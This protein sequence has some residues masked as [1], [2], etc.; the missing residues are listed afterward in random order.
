MLSVCITTYN[1]ASGL[2]RTLESLSKQTRMPDELII[3]DN[4]SPDN[5]ADIAEKWSAHFKNFKYLRN[6][7]NVGMPG[8]LNNAISACSG[9]FILNL[10]DADTYQPELIEK[11]EKLIRQHPEVGIVFWATSSNYKENRGIDRITNGRDFFLKHFFR[12]TSSKIW[13]TVLARKEVYDQLMPFDPQFK[14]WADVDMWMR[15]CL[16]WDI[17]YISDPLMELFKEEGQFRYW[18]WQKPLFIYQMFFLNIVRH[19]DDLE[20][21]E[22]A[23]KRQLL[24][25][26]KRWICFMGGKL[27]RGNLASF[28]RGLRYMPAY[29]SMPDIADQ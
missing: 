21:R 19:F 27:R 24:Q 25:Q 5:T 1:R 4:A 18:D 11:T 9:D 23:L 29:F 14:A 16:D 8:N 26:R 13:G 12:H 6:A 20:E 15:V 22:K 17:A 10:H 2:D 3:S 7:E 28:A